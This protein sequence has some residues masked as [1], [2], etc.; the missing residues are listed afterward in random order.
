VRHG[1]WLPRISLVFV[2][3]GLLIADWNF[4]VPKRY[5]KGAA[6]AASADAKGKQNV[7]PRGRK[8]KAASK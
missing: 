8:R 3:F 6:S 2:L 4:L 1:D 5:R 7:P